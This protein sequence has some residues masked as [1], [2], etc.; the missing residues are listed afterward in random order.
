MSKA[1]L[2][3]AVVN[4]AINTASETFTET[5]TDSNKTNNTT[6]I[7]NS[8]KGFSPTARFGKINPFSIVLF[9]YTVVVLS[10]LVNESNKVR[11][12]KKNTEDLKT[13]RKSAY[14]MATRITVLTFCI[15][16]SFFLF[17]KSI[18][19]TEANIFVYSGLF[20]LNLVIYYV[21]ILGAKL[22]N[23]RIFLYFLFWCMSLATKIALPYI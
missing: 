17:K 10:I 16:A 6:K 9:L 7:I 14:L 13:K 19:K 12:A 4:K 5:I 20:S 22:A 1:I 18:Q 8:L 15:F 11:N 3:E 2:N 23:F 21:I